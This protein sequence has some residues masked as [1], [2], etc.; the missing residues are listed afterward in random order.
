MRR[1]TGGT[2]PL[3]WALTIVFVGCAPRGQAPS[4]SHYNLSD[5]ADD[6]VCGAFLRR[7]DDALR[8]SDGDAEV[9][10]WL[11]DIH[12]NCPE[13]QARAAD[14]RLRESESRKRVQVSARKNARLA[15]EEA[16]ERKRR[17]EETRQREQAASED[18]QRMEALRVANEKADDA[19]WSSSGAG[20]CR[21]P[22][23]VNACDAMVAYLKS[24]PTGKHASEAAQI[25][26]DVEPTLATLRDEADWNEAIGENLSRTNVTICRAA[27]RS[28]ACA[29]LERYL[30]R[31]PSGAHAAEA[32]SVI[33]A[34]AKQI[35]VLRAKETAVAAQKKESDERRQADFDRVLEL[36][37]SDTDATPANDLREARI[38]VEKDPGFAAMLAS[39]G[40][41]LALLRQHVSAPTLELLRGGREV[42]LTERVC[43]A[44]LLM[45]RVVGAK[46]WNLFLEEVKG[47]F[48]G[49]PDAKKVMQI[50]TASNCN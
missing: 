34:T 36:L 2:A 39:D 18:A 20:G 19:N 30:G 38:M 31:H 10:H 40:G 12:D 46:A 3:A 26:K 23:E 16:A 9:Q 17:D 4:S 13:A 6:Q 7:F 44:R 43:Q 22:K 33:Q 48:H 35:A 45:Q 29:P 14:S 47:Q 27:E 5:S 8:S 24:R 49:Y 25:L 21:V 50:L 32:R 11:T 37:Q 42:G 28:D 15:E 41:V 1:A